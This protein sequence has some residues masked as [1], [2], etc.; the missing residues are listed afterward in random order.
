MKTDK[1]IV[2]EPKQMNLMDKKREKTSMKMMK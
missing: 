1:N 2:Q